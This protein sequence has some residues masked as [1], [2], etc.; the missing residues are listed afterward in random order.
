MKTLACLLLICATTLASAAEPKTPSSLNERADQFYAKYPT[1]EKIGRRLDE[2]SKAE[3]DNPEP[4]VMA[5]NAYRRCASRISINSGRQPGG[6]AVLKDPKTNK[7]VGTIGTQLDPKPMRLALATLVTATQK[8][9]DRLDLH[10]GRMT[11]AEELNDV[12]SIRNAGEALLNQVA[13]HPDKMDWSDGEVRDKPLPAQLA[14]HIHPHITKL[15][16]RQ[17]DD[18]DKAAWVLAVQALKL[19]PKDVRLLND[20]AVYHAY[21]QEWDKAL[22]YFTQAS[23]VDPTDLLVQHNIAQSNMKL[24]HVEEARRVWQAIVAKAP[25]GSDR[26]ESAE[27]ALK[28]LAESK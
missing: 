23:E 13:T 6:F 14:D 10:L 28:D 26:A 9:P 20:A 27:Q 19:A 17:E 2:W 24:G 7:Q 12:P 1:P 8:F 4:Y 15:Y 21:Q 16:T 18:S 11:L 25:A 5:A 22:A 3:P